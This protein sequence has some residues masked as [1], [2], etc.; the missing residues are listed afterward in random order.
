MKKHALLFIA[1]I[2]ILP[3]FVYSAANMQILVRKDAGTPLD[4]YDDYR[5]QTDLKWHWTPDF[6]LYQQGD[7]VSFWSDLNF[8][9]VR[10]EIRAAMDQWNAVSSSG[11]KFGGLHPHDHAPAGANIFGAGLD[12]YNLIT[13]ADWD[14]PGGTDVYAMTTLFYFRR[15]FDTQE[16]DWENPPPGILGI[17]ED[18]VYVTPSEEDYWDLEDVMGGEAG[19]YFSIPYLPYYKAGTIIDADIM[20]NP[21]PEPDIQIIPDESYVDDPSAYWGIPDVKMLALRELGHAIGLAN[22]L[23][24]RAVMTYEP[25]V[26]A[27]FG[28]TDEILTNPYEYRKL[29]MD[30]EIAITLTYPGKDLTSFPHIA[31]NVLDGEAYIQQDGLPE[32]GVIMA[33][34]VYLGYPVASARGPDIVMSDRGPIRLVAQVFSGIGNRFPLFEDD[35]LDFAPNGKFIFPN[36][37]PRNDW[38]I[39]I[40]PDIEAADIN[41]YVQQYSGDESFSAQFYGIDEYY[42]DY[43]QG[44]DVDNPDDDFV[45]NYFLEMYVNNFG[46]Y[47][48]GV[49]GGAM[50]LGNHPFPSRNYMSLRVEGSE[51]HNRQRVL[52][53]VVPGE[54]LELSDD[55]NM[56]EGTWRTNQIEVTQKTYLLGRSLYVE[57][58][59]KNRAPAPRS[60]DFRV[61]WDMA[62]GADIYADVY[63]G[64]TQQRIRRESRITSFPESLQFVDRARHPLVSTSLDLGYS[65]TD[66]L[67]QILLGNIHDMLDRTHTYSPSNKTLKDNIAMIL[68]YDGISLVANEAKKIR[69]K[70]DLVDFSGWRDVPYNF[71]S[72]EDE[73][74]LEQTYE[75]STEESVLFL[76]N[77]A[78][79]LDNINIFTDTGATV[80]YREFSETPTPPVE[81]KDV[82]QYAVEPSLPQIDSTS[83]SGR[84]ADLNGNGYLDL[85]LAGGVNNA[86]NFSGTVNRLLMNDGKGRFTDVSSEEGRFPHWQQE[87][88]Y[89]VLLE[90]FNNNGHIDIFVS[91]FAAPG[92][93][94]GAQ[95]RLF[96]NRGDGSFDDVTNEPANPDDPDS[97][98]VLP[99]VL[100]MGP[101]T[102][103][104]PSTRPAAGDINRSKY[105]DIIVANFGFVMNSPY[106]L[107]NRILINKMPEKGYLYFADETY[108]LNRVP[109]GDISSRSQ[110]DRLPPPIYV[111][112]GE[113]DSTAYI[114]SSLTYEVKLAQLVGDEMPDIFEVNG[115]GPGLVHTRDRWSGSF[116]A[117]NGSGTTYSNELIGFSN[118]LLQNVDRDYMNL[119]WDVT[120]P[121]DLPSSDG[122]TYADGYFV[123]ISFGYDYV[124]NQFGDRVFLGIPEGWVGNW[125]RPVDNVPEADQIPRTNADSRAAVIADFDMDGDNDIFIVNSQS[126]ELWVNRDGEAQNSTEVID[127]I[128]YIWFP[129]FF[130]WNG[131]TGTGGSFS[132]VYPQFI[133][134]SERYPN[135]L[136]PVPGGSLFTGADLIDINMNGV[137]DIVISNW[138]TDPEEAYQYVLMNNLDFYANVDTNWNFELLTNVFGNE[139]FRSMNVTVADIN[140]S[141]ADDVFFASGFTHMQDGK[142]SPDRLFQN[143]FYKTPASLDNEDSP[144]VFVNRTHDYLPLYNNQYVSTQTGTP[145]P[146]ERTFLNASAR[147]AL[148]D[149]NSSGWPDMVVANGAFH[150]TVGDYSTYFINTG[151]DRQRLEGETVFKVPFSMYPAPT[152]SHHPHPYKSF[153]AFGHGFLG[154]PYPGL[155]RIFL[156][157]DPLPSYSVRL[158]DVDNSGSYDIIQSNIGHLNNLF[159]NYAVNDPKYNTHPDD[160][161]RGDAVFYDEAYHD[162]YQAGLDEAYRFPIIPVDARYSRDFAV[163]DLNNNGYPDIIWANGMRSGGVQNRIFMNGRIDEDTGK[164]YYGF[165]EDR[166]DLFRDWVKDD[167]YC[168]V[169]FDMNNNGRRDII[170]GGMPSDNYPYALRVLEQLED[171]TFRDVTTEIFPNVSTIEGPVRQI[172]VGD[173][174]GEG[175]YTEDINGNGILDPGQD[176]NNNG[177]IDWS[178]TTGK[179]DGTRPYVS[180]DIF[181]VTE[182]RNRLFVN[183]GEGYF[184]D[185]T[186]THIPVEWRNSFDAAVGDLNMNGH[187]DIVL[188]N[189]MDEDKPIQV[190]INE[191]T[192]K[193]TDRTSIAFGLDFPFVG[194]ERFAR[195]IE[196]AD[197]DGDGDLDIVVAT[198][199]ASTHQHLHYSGGYNIVYINNTIGRNKPRGREVVRPPQIKNPPVIDNIDP[200]RI[201]VTAGQATEGTWSLRIEGKNFTT[202]LE[203]Y[204][205]PD[206]SILNVAYKS[207]EVIEVT[208]RFNRDNPRIGNR[209]IYLIDRPTRRQYPS[210]FELFEIVQEGTNTVETIKIIDDI[211]TAPAEGSVLIGDVDG[212]GSKD[213]IL[214]SDDV[215][216]I[217]SGQGILKKSIDLPRECVPAF[218][219]DADGDGIL[220]IFLGSSG[221]GFAAY[222][223]KGDGTLLQTFSGISAA[224]SGSIYPIALSDGKV[225]VGYG[226][227]DDLHLRGVARYDYNSGSKEWY[228]EADS[229]TDFYAVGDM[230]GDG[231]LDI[232]M[233]SDTRNVAADNMYLLVVDETGTEKLSIPY[234]EEGVVYH[235][236]A[237]MT[238][239]GNLEIVSFK[240]HDGSY[241][242]QSQIRIFDLGGVELTSFNG[243]ADELW[244]YAVDDITGDGKQEVVVTTKPSLQTYVLDSD[245]NIL[246]NDSFPGKVKLAGDLNGTGT[247][248]IVL[249]SEDG[250]LMVLDYNLEKRLPDYK[251]LAADAGGAVFSADV[252]GDGR[253]E[254]VCRTQVQALSTDN[255]YVLRLAG[256]EQY[257]TRVESYSVP[258]VIPQDSYSEMTVIMRNVGARSWAKDQDIY[259]S[260]LDEEDSLVHSDN[261]NIALH[262]DVAPGDYHTFTII[263]EPGQAGMFSTAWRMSRDDN[264]EKVWFGETLRKKVEVTP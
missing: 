9:D 24:T 133:N 48:I 29:K 238:G 22:S 70:Y 194:T 125:I 63:N 148:G 234:N 55:G 124:T 205:G 11:F 76:D 85:V 121:G 88:T 105:S 235:E 156:E 111:W 143:Q 20:Y 126:W 123:N 51:S 107:S 180:Y 98:T 87:A 169:A 210:R 38:V 57:Y 179:G 173:F 216:K 162:F 127:G 219:D 16:I 226:A 84:F 224:G 36:I 4:P 106:P 225:L 68:C 122:N 58:T 251:K 119:S 151:L 220:D 28:D 149:L 101:F 257:A 228:Y 255:I 37:P 7:S 103:G 241:P 82:S 252:T 113:T 206:I 25:F 1:I 86:F 164:T 100:D 174:T 253:H 46:Q 117:T 190:L 245:L 40:D 62:I 97:P 196:L 248:E 193:F 204:M 186:S 15:S 109:G 160:D 93:A 176:T 41:E 182:G 232:T 60:M 203:V 114:K 43:L 256:M 50:L 188:T 3:V 146:H 71:I 261:L 229:V 80:P 142:A 198:D 192:G 78:G 83:L 189:Y 221:S 145:G 264:D 208:F 131:T 137:Y 209:Q 77:T 222:V 247:Q 99:G 263:L 163:A 242:G 207:S 69:I 49:P 243:G 31:G 34:P 81:F 154:G 239:D 201:P 54:A 65:D 118:S 236:Y 165:F 227:Q 6:Y 167:S 44:F 155:E 8:S 128:Y 13:F 33:N 56:A 233:S 2:C 26:S 32:N 178:N 12:G 147:L 177:I 144:P 259:L 67:S 152:A 116:V 136:P 35:E 21:D 171:G 237:D 52:G 10:N 218:L 129:K 212:D 197:L 158:V 258:S 42:L 150:T 74:G 172:M 159:I 95:N 94:S 61:F 161:Y 134:F 246:Q 92:F 79:S 75:I 217:Y 30:D 244:Y 59:L 72:F 110:R 168:V 260:A 135:I 200:G 199:V 64:D 27:D 45:S 141:G 104:D 184:T 17:I 96:L 223:Y 89:D 211:Q 39:Y 73:E 195:G 230:D 213:I 214:T 254:L 175:D 250:R 153:W 183:D 23:L 108:G 240:G 140:N 47:S 90:D 166:T 19:D 249:L 185:V 157:P 191:G 130:L 66:I 102:I 187:L 139:P 53:S 202:S 112:I 115:A 91:N 5:E 215:L 14:F 262:K 120:F 132:R 170:F 18:R 138:G 231:V 181:L